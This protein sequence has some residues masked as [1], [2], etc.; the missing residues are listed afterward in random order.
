ML[1]KPI[2]NYS[3]SSRFVKL[4]PQSGYFAQIRDMRS[5]SN[6]WLFE[7]L[8]YPGTD[9]LFENQPAQKAFQKFIKCSLLTVEEASITTLIRFDSKA[10]D[11]L[12]SFCTL[13]EPSKDWNNPCAGTIKDF[14]HDKIHWTRKGGSILRESARRPTDKTSFYCTFNS[15]MSL[16][17]SF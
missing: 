1:K 8:P 12:R 10:S 11:T 13:L 9:Q 17:I 3:S 6:V 5:A 4:K 2:G 14:P 15:F 16:F 7:K